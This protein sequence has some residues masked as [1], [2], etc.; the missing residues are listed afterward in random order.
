M[1][2]SK[3]MDFPGAKK[4][5]YAAQVEQSQATPT[6]DN[7]L[8]FL[9]VPGPVGPQGPAGRDGRDGK[10]GSQGPEG[11]PG[12]KGA[13]GSAGKDG[14]SS[15]SSS[16]QQ[17]GWA[18][19]HNKVEKP[20]KLGISEG[21]DGWVTIFLLSEGLSN[22]K[23]LPKG[24]TPLWNDHARAFNFRG[25][26]EGAQVFITYSFELTTYSSNTEA[27]IRTYS[28][29]SGLDIA[30]FIG[31]M[32]YQHTYP[33]TVTQQVFIEN[34]KIWGNG[35]VPQIRTDY[36]ASVIIKSIYVSVV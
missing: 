28:T 7:A 25:L 15:L 24:C 27:W 4:S 12:P 5:S 36:D 2:V 20:F 16:G 32:K 18:S 8:S 35:A 9:P 10:E 31:S 17:A 21:D 29:N 30:Q 19:Y 33:I 13:Q 11:K 1:A 22:E 14:L 23:Y 3:S 6:V 34:Q 26:E